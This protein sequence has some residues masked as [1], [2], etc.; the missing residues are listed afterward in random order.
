MSERI[1]NTGNRATIRWQ[2][3]TGASA[4]ALAGYL[5]S[6]DMAR[7][8]AAN[9]PLVWIEA[10]GQFSLL[11]DD[12]EAFLPPF[13]LTSPYDDAIKIANKKPP[14]EWD[15]G[16]KVSFQPSDSDWLLSV[17]IKYGK[18][19]RHKAGIQYAKNKGGNYQKYYTAYQSSKGSSSEKHIILDFQA[20]KDFGLGMFGH[21]GSSVVSLGLRYA[22]FNSQSSLNIL[23]AT[24]AVPTSYNLFHGAFEAT[25]KFSGIGPSLTWDAS[26][27]LAG[28]QARGSFNFD[29][30]VNGALLFGRQRVSG[31]HEATNLYQHGTAKYGPPKTSRYHI[32][33]SPV[34]NKS[35]IVPNLGGY[36]ALSLNYAN[37][38]IS[39]GYRADMFFGAIDGGID[40]VKKEDRGF[41]GPFMSV[42]VGLGG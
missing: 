20:G 42:S 3:L 6:A 7:A 14:S 41:Y 13:A 28:N 27:N 12:N 19:S 4:L 23:S 39:F 36:A 26:A 2:L 29:W 17:G 16:L 34:R 8:D 38:K 24:A 30:G 31:H 22:Q 18:N 32:T 40:T 37:A 35:L 25:R 15:E 33:A 5:S 1:N 21:E 11:S 9:R 10:D